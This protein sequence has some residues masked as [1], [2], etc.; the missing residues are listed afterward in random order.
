MNGVGLVAV[1]TPAAVTAMKDKEEAQSYAH[2]N[3]DIT[4]PKVIDNLSHYV[5]TCWE[6]ARDH[7]VSAGLTDRLLKCDRQRRGEYDPEKLAEIRKTGGSEI[8][9]MLTDIKCRA[10]LAWIKDVM[11]AYGNE[12]WTLEPTAEPSITPD[13]REAIIE[14]VAAEAQQ[15]FQQGVTAPNPMVFKQRL[16]EM[17]DEVR[18]K[19]MDAAVKASVNMA[20]RIRDQMEEGDWQKAFNDFANDFVT[21]PAAFI[22]GPVI[23]RTKVLSWGE[24]YKPIV[25]TEAKRKFYRLSPYDAF[26]SPEASSVQDGYFCERV[27]FS[28]RD[29]QS[30]RGVK[31]YRDDEIDAVVNEF[32]QGG[33]REWLYGDTEKQILDGKGPMW[34]NP[35]E[36]IDGVE[37]WGHASGKVLTEW[38]MK[39]CKPTE[40]YDVT[41]ILIGNHV[42]RATL[43]P[44]PMGVRPYSSAC[45]EEVAGTIWG[46]CPPEL[47]RDTAVMCN[48]AARALANNVAL[49]SGPMV[50]VT[51]DRLPDGERV[52]SVSPWRLYQTT[53]DKTGGGQPAVR[54]YQPQMHAQELLEIFRFF[55]QKA[56]EVTGI[57][58]Y[59]YGTGS[60]GGAG[61]TASGLGM[62]MDNASKGI[63]QAIGNIDCAITVVLTTMYNHN[64]LYDPD[65]SIKGDMQIVA[66]GAL[67]MVMREQIQEKR[68][69]F[70]QATMNPIDA[71]IMGPEGRGYLLSEVAK[72]LQLDVKKIVPTPQKLAQMKEQMAQSAAQQQAAEGGGPQNI[73]F[74]RDADGAVTGAQVMPGA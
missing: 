28:I 43:N 54:F 31:G 10:A 63:K 42:I 56:D 25:K 27:R 50:E 60:T 46:T 12:T 14:G 71:Q 51:I 6:R 33:L 17:T 69:G 32:A 8:Y 74:Q 73:Q 49:A 72:P 65:E 26:P 38:G 4:Q 61:R 20:R 11:N 47:M 15:A 64:M 59:V 48:A 40:S 24:D 37:F 67:G 41:C 35:N 57:P 30:I 34:V 3:K 16:E 22:K 9:M 21:F 36:M 55:S 5:K 52:T 58:N 29:L 7:K 44:D 45:F 18:E 13:L 2:Q 66:K 62:L 39:G 19:L 23:R 1:A 53:S 70:L 68:Q